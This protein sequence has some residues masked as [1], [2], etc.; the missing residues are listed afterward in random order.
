MPEHQM[1][2]VRCQTSD[3]VRAAGPCS[4]AEKQAALAARIGAYE[5]LLVA[6]SGGVDSA[7]LAVT[8]L[9]VLGPARMLA[10]L[11]VSAS[12]ARDVHAR[13]RMLAGV[14]GVPFREVETHELDDGDYVANRGD[15]C[16]HCKQEL[17][18]RLVP[19]ARES[20]FAV[21]ADGTIAEDLHEHRPGGAAGARAGIVSP[22]AEC[23]FTKHDVRAAARARGIPIWDAPAAPCLASRL[24]VGVTVTPERLASIDRAE[25]AL[26]ALGIAGDLRVRNLGDAA[27]IELPAA[28]LGAWDDG[29]HHVQLA[30]AVRSAGFERVLFDRRGYRRGA[31]QERQTMDAADVIDITLG[32]VIDT[33]P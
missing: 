28:E 10:V 1:S 25:S 22:L 24:A 17:W 30:A 21:V 12:M 19:I 20:G 5:S 8:A 14:F 18:R 6:F 26:R 33:L 29:A 9:D 16:F 13:A 27:R 7:L 11:G 4:L 31:L 32:R 23:G 3:G 2:E 15:R